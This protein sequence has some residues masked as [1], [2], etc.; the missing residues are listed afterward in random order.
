MVYILSPS[1]EDAAKLERKYKNNG[2]KVKV[3]QEEYDFILSLDFRNP[4]AALIII[5]INRGLEIIEGLKLDIPFIQVFT[6]Q[7]KDDR[8]KQF[9]KCGARDVKHS[10]FLDE[11]VKIT[12]DF[13]RRK[14]DKLAHA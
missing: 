8:I 11:P 3:F 12:A 2:F 14:V 4:P 10:S 5:D 6:D 13:I 9:Y 1:L 7:Y